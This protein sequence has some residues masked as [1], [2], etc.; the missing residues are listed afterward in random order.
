MKNVK[1]ALEILAVQ[2]LPARFRFLEYREDRGKVPAR[3]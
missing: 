3:G 2:G 1:A